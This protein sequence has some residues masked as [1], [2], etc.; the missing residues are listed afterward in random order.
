MVGAAPSYSIRKREMTPEQIGLVKTSFASV[1]P[2]ANQAGALFYD[3]LFLLDPSLRPMFKG[4]ISEQSRTLM[5]MIAAAVNG[6]DRLETIV[7]TVQA[8][9][10]RHAEYG[11]VN[12]HYQTVAAALLW[13]LQQGLGD[14]FTSEVSDAWSAAYGVLAE[15]MQSAARDAS[16]TS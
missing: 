6:L 9:G 2:I 14:R 10:V 11:V 5:R 7:P 12:A 15:T 4:D 3:R 13:A 1:S 16:Q 8:L